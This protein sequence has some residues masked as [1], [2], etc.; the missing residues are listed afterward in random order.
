M[1]ASTI[2]GKE[3][4]NKALTKVIGLSLVALAG[5]SLYASTPEEGV[6][7]LKES[8][9]PTTIEELGLPEIPDEENGALVYREVFQLKKSLLQKYQREWKYMPY[10]STVKWS[11]V[12]AE[13]K[14]KV[15]D[16]IL[17]NPDV[18]RL[19]QLLEKASKMECQ[20]LT[21]EDYQQDVSTISKILLPHLSELRDCVRLSA[22]KAKTEAESGQV[23]KALSI[24]L[25]GLRIGKSLANEPFLI[26]QLVRIAIDSIALSRLEEILNKGEGNTDL[27]QALLYEMEEERKRNIVA[28]SLKGEMVIFGMPGMLRERESARE[29]SKFFKKF[30]NEYW[31]EEVSV[32]IK[33]MSKLIPLCAKP[34]WD[35]GK[36][37]K[38]VVEEV[39][40]LPPRRAFLAK[41][42]IST[43]PRAYSQ[44]AKLDA[45]LGAAEIAVANRI[46]RKKHG[47]YVNSLEQLS[48]EILPVLPLDPFTG[49]DYIYK[50]KDKGFI[51]YSLGKNLRDDGGLRRKARE[52]DYDIV[53]ECAS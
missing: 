9:V 38:E 12:P 4:I 47:K 8:G 32:Y 2:E 14:K 17:H 25:T 7:R 35:A 28:Y 23:E 20:F 26:S 15:I 46:H 30:I 22:A 21:K 36:K 16:F 45:H 34:Y 42:V 48:P 52:K 3:K 19:Y 40:S 41:N 11:E 6:Q 43:V 29:A 53:W 10:V 5:L 50:K 13:K 31:D 33:S 24:S 44:E 37:V 27:Y 51:V 1:I 18:A 39:K 49:K